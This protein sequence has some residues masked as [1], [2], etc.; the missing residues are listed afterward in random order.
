MTRDDE[1]DGKAERHTNTPQDQK[2][3]EDRTLAFLPPHTRMHYN[4][5]DARMQNT[6]SHVNPARAVTFLQSMHGPQAGQEALLR[7][8]TAERL[9]H[10]VTAR[11]WLDVYDKLVE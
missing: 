11:Y 8:L 6:L 7:A 1:P 10:R 9:L 5:A 3:E 4:D 2:P